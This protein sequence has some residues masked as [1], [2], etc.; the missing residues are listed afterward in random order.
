MSKVGFKLYFYQDN[1]LFKKVGVKKGT[2]LNLTVGTD[3]NCD[4]IIH[5]N[6]VSRKHLQIIY[7]EN[8]KLTVT[9]LNSTNGTFLNG[10]ELVSAS[11]H[12]LKNKDKLHLS[13]GNGVLIIIETLINESILNTQTN[14]I[15]ILNKKNKINIGR[16]PDCDIILDNETVSRY[17]ATI[18]KT[19][20]GE[21]IIQDLSSRNG[22]FVNGQKI[23]SFTNVKINDKIFIGRH[24]ISLEGE[25]T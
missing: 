19:Y 9:D 13:G 23:K 11:S 1:K 25:N 14:I 7:T 12:P 16:N 17:H 5:N 4:I 22:T 21:Y 20:N 15:D 8:G 24:Q 10:I 18:E 2:N 6:R 3:N